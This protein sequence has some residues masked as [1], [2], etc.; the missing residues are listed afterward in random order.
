[1]LKMVTYNVVKAI[2]DRDAGM[3][4]SEVLSRQNITPKS[5]FMGVSRINDLIR[6]NPG[7]VVLEEIAADPIRQRELFNMGEDCIIEQVRRGSRFYDGIFKHPENVGYIIYHKLI[8]QRPAMASKDRSRVIASIKSMPGNLGEYL[9]K[10]LGGSTYSCSVGKQADSWL[11]VLHVFDAVYQAKTGDRSLF[12]LTA[13][14]HLHEWFNRA[15]KNYWT[16]YE[17]VRKVVYHV[18]TEKRP[19]LASLD[20][21]VVIKEI[22]SLPDNLV[23]YFESIGLYGALQSRFV[24][25]SPLNLLMIFDEE[26]MNVT[27]DASLFDL[28]QDNHLH[29][30]DFGSQIWVSYEKR[31]EAVAHILTT[32]HPGL[33]T[34]TRLEVLSIIEKFPADLIKYFLSIGLANSMLGRVKK[35]GYSSQRVL[36]L[37]DDYFKERSGEP[38]LFDK[39]L[40]RRLEFRHGR[41][42][43]L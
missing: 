11:A 2:I 28:K 5:F 40:R 9:E 8:N 27:G 18:L 36:R 34:G 14:E 32:E 31:K 19:R 30:W 7:D 29:I 39:R 3:P 20:R 41:R 15:S 26:Y 6:D 42:V 22:K 13:K 17:I 38:S 35:G 23:E 33:A 24:K 4:Y 37:Y 25:S 16:N 12:D 21:D 10:V 43:V 1:V